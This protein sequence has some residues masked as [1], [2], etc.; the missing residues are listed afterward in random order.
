MSRSWLLPVLTLVALSGCGSAPGYEEVGGVLEADHR[1]RLSRAALIS[2]ANSVCAQRSLAIDQLPKPR[3]GAE[4]AR[5]FA[6]VA[7]IER[8]EAR[9]LATLR[10]PQ[11][12]ERDYAALLAAS[13]ELASVAARFHAAVVRDDGY[14]RR[15]ALADA[16]QASAAYD[17]AARRLGLACRQSV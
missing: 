4:A 7:T 15:I 1:P 11:A 13:A 17:R 5:F 12:L 10:P 16:D 14:E 6:R 2:T 8:D 9:A 3:R